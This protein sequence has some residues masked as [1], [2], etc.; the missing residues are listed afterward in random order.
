ME[1][2]KKTITFDDIKEDIIKRL[3]T[4]H[5][6]ENFSIVEHIFYAYSSAES[7]IKKNSYLM[8]FREGRI[9]YWPLIFFVDDY[10]I[11]CS[12]KGK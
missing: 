12:T 5:D 2:N 10:D 9:E 6:N 4:R 3:K 1:L 7:D 8:I 11:N